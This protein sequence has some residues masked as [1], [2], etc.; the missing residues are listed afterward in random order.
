MT[1]E[2]TKCYLE[3]AAGDEEEYQTKL[4]HYEDLGRWLKDNASDDMPDRLEDLDDEWWGILGEMYEDATSVCVLSAVLSLLKSSEHLFRW[5]TD[6]D[7]T[8]WATTTVDFTTHQAHRVVFTR[9]QKD[10]NKLL[11]PL[12]RF[13]KSRQQVLTLPAAE[14]QRVQSPSHRARFRSTRRGSHER[15]RVRRGIN[16]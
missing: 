4:R 10:D 14:I 7:R 13:A 9:A 2:G 12:D 5:V 6:S 11:R 16:M 15:R 8:I 1:S 3:L